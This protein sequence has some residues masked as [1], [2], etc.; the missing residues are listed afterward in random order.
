[1]WKVCVCAGAGFHRER[2]YHNHEELASGLLRLYGAEAIFAYILKN[3][4][5]TFF[6]IFLNSLYHK[7][8]QNPVA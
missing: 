2:L 1:V 8:L 7:E 5:Y 4:E 3:G 6:L